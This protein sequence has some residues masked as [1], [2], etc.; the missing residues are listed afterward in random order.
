[1]NVVLDM[2]KVM[3]TQTTAKRQIYRWKDS[4]GVVHFSSEDPVSH[5]SPSWDVQKTD[6]FP[7]FD[8][9]DVVKSKKEQ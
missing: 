5:V 6:K 7:G 9:V 4:R 2:A 1:V 8:M 3:D